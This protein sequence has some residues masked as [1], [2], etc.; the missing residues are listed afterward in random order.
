MK[1]RKKKA[2]IS[3]EE[4]EALYHKVICKNR[5]LAD[6]NTELSNKCNILEYRLHCF[7]SLKWYQ[8]FMLFIYWSRFRK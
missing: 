8:L 6:K 5:I 3:I 4:R 2:L 7:I 1:E